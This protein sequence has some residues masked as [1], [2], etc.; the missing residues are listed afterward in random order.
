MQTSD[1]PVNFQIQPIPIVIAPFKNFLI[2]SLPFSFQ[3]VN[4]FT[5]VVNWL[6]YHFTPFADPY[7]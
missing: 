7:V 1:T 3:I 4:R 2:A 5:R 6:D